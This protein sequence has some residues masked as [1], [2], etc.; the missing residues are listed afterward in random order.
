M[1]Q[2]CCGLLAGLGCVGM[3][4]V[5]P[6][7]AE[8]VQW[9]GPSPYLSAADTPEG[10]V[11]PNPGALHVLEDFEDGSVDSI[12]LINKG[13]I[14]PPT[15]APGVPS[16]T[17]SVDGDDGAIDGTG[18][19]ASGGHSWFWNG[20]SLTI[21]FGQLVTSAGLVWTD[22]DAGLT[23]VLLE[24]LDLEG[25]LVGTLDAG[26]LADASYR[27]TTA[28]DRFL[29][30]SYGDGLNT[31]IGALRVVHVDGGPGIEV[32]HL[33]VSQCVVA[34]PEPAGWGLLA[35]VLGAIG[36]AARRRWRAGGG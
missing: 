6:A 14:S 13:Q 11:C 26:A 36:S 31:G 9:F 16:L 8:T 2:V 1:R 17:D 5:T 15:V 25:G 32:D 20:Q 35:V 7:E 33:Q 29:G 22:G 18:Q 24:V 21:S 28:E 23:S 12:F 34:V 4:V 3:M 10:F 27:G 19:S 30:A